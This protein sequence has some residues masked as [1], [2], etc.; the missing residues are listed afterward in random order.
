MKLSKNLFLI[1]MFNLAF[2]STA[3]A[4]QG[5]PL[6]DD[7]MFYCALIGEKFN[8]KLK[9]NADPKMKELSSLGLAVYEAYLPFAKNYINKNK[10]TSQAIQSAADSLDTQP[11]SN[12]IQPLLNC[13]DNP[14]NKVTI[15]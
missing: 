1:L 14:R 5:K 10:L 3:H 15:R 6:S 11:L 9:N 12:L 7:V 2:F 8:I 13:R 4:Q